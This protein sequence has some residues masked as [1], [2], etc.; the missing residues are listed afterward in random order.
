MPTQKDDPN[1]L[2]RERKEKTNP[3]DENYD[4]PPQNAFARRR[5]EDLISYYDENYDR[6][7]IRKSERGEDSFEEESSP[8]DWNTQKQP[9]PPPKW[10]TEDESQMYEVPYDVPKP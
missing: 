3:Y 1:A 9:P 10:A 8:F 5:K 4:I 2:S 7:P 6:K